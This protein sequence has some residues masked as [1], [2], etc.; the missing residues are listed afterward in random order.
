MNGS[1]EKSKMGIS[2]SS[3]SHKNLQT[4]KRIWRSIPHAHF[5]LNL[6]FQNCCGLVGF[7]SEILA[8]DEEVIARRFQTM[9]TNQGDE[10]LKFD[11]VT[12]IIGCWNGLVKRESNSNVISANP[13][14]R[15]IAFCWN[16]S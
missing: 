15:A 1:A 3:E 14:K 9:L 8:V 12:K 7:V 6:S 5:I 13:M 4:K 16:D 2:I 11:D 10:E